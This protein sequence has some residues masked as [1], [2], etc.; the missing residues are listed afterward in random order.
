MIMIIIMIALKSAISSLRRE[1]SPT[2]TPK[3]SSAI[4]SKSR[5]SDRALIMCN[6]S[7]ANRL[8]STGST[9][10]ALLFVICWLLKSQLH[11]SVSQVRSCSY[12]C[13]CCH[14]ETKVADQ[15]S[16]LI[17]SQY[18]GTGPTSVIFTFLT[19]IVVIIIIICFYYKHHSVCLILA[20]LLERFLFQTLNRLVRMYITACFLMPSITNEGIQI[21]VSHRAR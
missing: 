17:Q 12:N 6:M 14:T 8:F 16:Y 20:S 10:S 18:T 9:S 7:C 5:T 3:W 21:V 13:T 11:A 15:T 4:V 19:I 2:H 1:L